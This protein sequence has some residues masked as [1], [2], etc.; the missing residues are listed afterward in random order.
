MYIYKEKEHQQNDWKQLWNNGTGPERWLMR[1]GL[2][3]LVCAMMML[4]E[5]Y[6]M[7][8]AAS[9]IDHLD[10]ADWLRRAMVNT[11][12]QLGPE[13]KAMVRPL[14]EDWLWY[15]KTF[16]LKTLVRPEFNALCYLLDGH[17]KRVRRMDG[18]VTVLVGL[19]GMDRQEALGTLDGG[20]YEF[21]R[22]W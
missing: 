7:G 15:D 3:E 20:R 9:W 6:G 19:R 10:D 21:C 1:L 14:Y 18:P 12:N 17:G 5:D 11:F 22:W 13:D 8:W 2:W 4:S 16:D